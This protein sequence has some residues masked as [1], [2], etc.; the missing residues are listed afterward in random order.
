MIS[1]SHI[2]ELLFV[3]CPQNYTEV[4]LNSHT[5]HKDESYE[6]LLRKNNQ[7]RKAVVS[8]NYK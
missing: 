7:K 2:G 3:A 4:I 5:T 8:T 1:G 6:C